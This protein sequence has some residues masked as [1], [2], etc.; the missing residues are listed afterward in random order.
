MK[1]PIM[2]KSLTKRPREKN[3]R[4]FADLEALSQGVAAEIANL[5]S[6]AITKKGF[7]ALVLAG[8]STPRKLY[9]VLAKK[10]REKVDWP[11]V[12]FFWGDERCVPPNDSDSNFAM[13]SQTLLSRLAIPTQNVHRMPADME[14]PDAAAQAYEKEL[15]NF[16]N[17]FSVKSLPKFDLILLG[18]GEDG[19]TASLFPK[20]AALG[21]TRR[22]VAP[23]IA[24][25]SYKTRSRI[26]L[27][28]PV[29]NQAQ[30]VF[31]LV[32]GKEKKSLIESLIHA[33]EFSH[34]HF[35]A[36]RVAPQG[37]LL[38]FLDQA[39]GEALVSH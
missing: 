13:A 25:E 7:F 33:P 18:V 26:T 36:A 29:I 24:P 35:P 1:K 30:N 8:G 37:E 4:I 28:L 14:T 5:A 15:R 23:V 9:E 2:T 31:F 12:H 39:A 32:A 38:W 3:I 11:K 19:H 27:T 6:Q 34:A 22:W 16:F 17:L 21:E 20:T 10:Y